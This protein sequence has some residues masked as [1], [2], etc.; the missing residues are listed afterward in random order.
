M[1]ILANLPL[2]V[3][4]AGQVQA[5]LEQY[6][7]FGLLG[8]LVIASLGLP[9]PEDIPLIAAGVVLKLQPETANWGLTILT[10]LLGI[11]SGDL[12]LY[13]VGRWWGRDVVQHK[14][15]S[16]LITPALFARAERYFHKYGAWFCFFGRFIVG[17]RAVMCM[18]AG[19]TRYPYWRFFLADFSGALLSVPFFIGLGYVFA[20]ALEDLFHWIAEVQ[21]VALIVVA[22][23][24]IGFVLWELRRIRSARK[25]PLETVLETAMESAP[26]ADH[27]TTQAGGVLSPTQ[28][29]AHTDSPPAP[30]PPI[31]RQKA[32]SSHHAGA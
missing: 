4:D 15:V 5:L 19:A 2:A 18:T 21:G 28:P 16:W 31:H 26:P 9:I 25:M 24:V 23:A 13:T 30:P 22:V 10:A 17:I 8:I 29:P 7:Y 12:V 27:S 32:V 3:I 1:L 14:A 20:H 6:F 11:M